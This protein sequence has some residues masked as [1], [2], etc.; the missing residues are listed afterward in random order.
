MESEAICKAFRFCLKA[1][2]VISSS[3]YG[4][5]LIS[6]RGNYKKINRLQSL[7]LYL[8]SACVF[9]Y[10]LISCFNLSAPFLFGIHLLNGLISVLGNI[11]H[12]V[13]AGALSIPSVQLCRYPVII[14]GVINYLAPIT[15][16]VKG[17]KRHIIISS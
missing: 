11:L 9:L 12:I 13:I 8:G 17:K 4:F 6:R 10:I 2:N 5:D 16:A 7:R 14:C 3:P 15:T 1:C